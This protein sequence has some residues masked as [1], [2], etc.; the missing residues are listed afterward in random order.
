[1]M[2]SM[3]DWYYNGFFSIP[4]LSNL[5]FNVVMNYASLYG[6]HVWYWYYI[7]GLATISGLLYPILIY[8]FVSDATRWIRCTM[9]TNKSN[10]SRR[11]PIM[12]WNRSIIWIL[13]ISYIY[14]V[15]WNDHKEFR[16][17][18]PILPLVFLLCTPHV[19]DLF[20]T[21]G[22]TLTSKGRRR[23]RNNL[24]WYTLL[25]LVWVVANLI[26][27]IYLGLYH[28]SGPVTV[29]ET[30]VSLAKAKALATNTLE[31][32]TSTTKVFTIHY[33]TGACHSTPLQSHL[34]IPKW[35]SGNG[36]SPI[37]F[38]T[39]H[40]NCHPSCRVEAM[41]TQGRVQCE[42]D[43]FDTDPIS[44]LQSAYCVNDNTDMSL[45]TA[46]KCRPIPDYM[47]TFSHYMTNE[48]LEMLQY[49]PY[50]FQIID[51]YPNHLRG[52]QIQGLFGTKPM[53]FG[54]GNWSMLTTG[55]NKT[56]HDGDDDD[57]GKDS[58]DPKSKHNDNTDA[59]ALLE[60][61]YSYDPERMI[62]HYQTILSGILDV[63]W[64]AVLLLVRTDNPSQCR[65]KPM[66]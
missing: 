18:S 32:D 9:P 50:C 63:N 27:L 41:R 1:M 12:L 34:H 2:A 26:A 64:D 38:D 46:Q 19:R 49:E 7:P 39:W 31:S 53:Q 62:Y 22:G 30:I 23:R 48:V 65:P 44:F 3:M 4:I 24:V 66:T 20:D 28:Q 8:A 47:V 52:I 11:I 25:G 36:V 13:L 6:A 37:Q 10:P 35:D 56:S 58:N 15:S 42:T 61:M 17:I 54:A 16:Y 55:T 59:T 21:I 60:G 5:Y 40:L 43:Q 51:R 45:E 29:N 14:V 33:L 57:D